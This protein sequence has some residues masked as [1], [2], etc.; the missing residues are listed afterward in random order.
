MDIL[1]KQLFRIHSS[2]E[3]PNV[4]ILKSI[5]KPN[6]KANDFIGFATYA[7]DSQKPKIIKKRNNKA[8]IYGKRAEYYVGRTKYINWLSQH[9]ELETT[10]P[11]AEM[12]K[13]PKLFRYENGPRFNFSAVFSENHSGLNPT[14]VIHCAKT[15]L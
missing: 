8:I 5:L 11:A 10:M 14:Q 1:G 15:D 9:F 2:A 7:M 12:E 4:I 6:V 3:E 13:L